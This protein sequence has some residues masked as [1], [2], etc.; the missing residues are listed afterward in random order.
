M[1]LVNRMLKNL[2]NGRKGTADG[3]LQGLE[4]PLS[5]PR[6]RSWSTLS[7]LLLL[8]LALGGGTLV[9]RYCWTS[10]S[11]R[12]PSAP[13]KP[14]LAVVEPAAKPSASAP[15]ATRP[16]A[17]PAP[18][19]TAPAESSAPQPRLDRLRAVRLS[20]DDSRLRLVL[21]TEASVPYTLDEP[22]PGVYRWRLA[23]VK[24]AAKLVLPPRTSEVAGIELS[25]Q[26]DELQITA[27]LRA[28]L[29]HRDFILPPQANFGARIV[30]D[31]TLPPVDRSAP[32]SPARKPAPAAAS[33][34]AAKPVPP[35]VGGPVVRPATES[36]ASRYQL[37][38]DDLRQGRE[39][40]ALE[41]L[42][43]LLEDFPDYR[44]GREL[45]AALLAR[46]GRPAEAES[47]LRQGVERNPDY[48]PFRIGYGRLLL[49]RG[50]LTEVRQ[51]LRQRPVPT[52]DQ[53][54][55]YH[56]LAAAVAQA[57]GDYAHA[58][59]IYSAL[60]HRQDRVQWWLGLAVAAEGEGRAAK[61]RDA[62]RRV[63]ADE[64]A[65]PAL[66]QFARQR[67]Q[68]LKERTP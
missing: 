56:A 36:A 61:A 47:V 6:R 39:G 10:V 27:R 42:R 22:E 68:A 8:L 53:A 34:P 14:Q 23:G 15:P 66:Q 67:L 33:V 60:L 44:Q 64:T 9:G 18:A 55:E 17:P 7:L 3:V 26:G 54:P 1:S 35:T 46:L 58:A 31:F 30:T 2:E 50:A 63:L 12:Q 32:S 65:G 52:L 38:Q 29:A 28:P 57:S 37:A 49:E 59:S 51:L 19:A 45:L 13:E 16:L 40:A 21:E 5:P 25:T 20:E 11:G 62:Y 4:S 24:P 48:L 41:R 43:R